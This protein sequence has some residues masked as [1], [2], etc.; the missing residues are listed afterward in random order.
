MNGT[1]ARFAEAPSLDVTRRLAQVAGGVRGIAYTLRAHDED[2]TADLG[3]S[4][5]GPSGQA[6]AVTVE[7]NTPR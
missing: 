5:L 4:P 3:P 1:E 7:L 2:H 6:E